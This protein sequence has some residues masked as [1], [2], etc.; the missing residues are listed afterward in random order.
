M[1][2]TTIDAAPAA[3]RMGLVV[4]AS[5]AGTIFEWYDFFIFGTLAAI[6]GKHFF[7]S[8]G[9]TQGYIFALL[10]FAAGYAVRPL[11]AVVFGRIGDRTGRKRAFLVTITIMG[12]ATLAVGFLPDFA[13][14]GITAPYALVSLRVLQGFAIGGE[15]GGAAIF[16]AEHAST[17]RRGAAT[18]WIQTSATLG[19]LLALAIVLVTR[20]TLGEDTFDAWGWRIPFL[21]S[22][23]LL[24]VSIWIRLKLHESPM[25]RKMVAE[26]RGSSAPLSESFLRWSNLKIMLIALFGLLAGQGVVWYTAQ[27]YT[28]VFLEHVIKVEP[29]AVNALIMVI[30]AIGAPLHMFFAWLSDKIGRK[31]V[32]LFG[33]GLAAICYLPGFQMLAEAANPALTAAA[34]RSP[35]VVVAAPGSCSF[36]F[37]P[38]G[39]AKFVSSCD[40]AKGALANAGVPY[41]NEAAEGGLAKVQMGTVTLTSPDGT[42]RNAASAAATKKFTAELKTALSQAGYP[43]SAKTGEIDIPRTLEILLVFIVAA[44]ALYG[45]QAAAL[46]ELFPTRIRYTA[47]SVPYHI[48]VGWFGG[49]LPT[50]AFAIVVATGNIYAGLWYPAA[51]AA[52]GFVV[53]LLFLP[54]TRGRDIEA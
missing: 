23:L 53:T 19:L 38:I 40:I 22:A 8:A 2:D 31:P 34:A 1:A 54:E 30:A 6:I 24:A 43:A 42:A 52:I 25:F 4:T 44:A 27:F 49:F 10:T 26:G 47:L 46:V 32:M 36:Q 3:P 28:Q 51:I 29:A 15:Y 13:Q 41:R 5:A 18:G 39:K 11:G 12:L 20:K 9:D 16:V 37:D 7:S 45:P 21:V 50:I 33:L 48:G 14:I 17:R 35:V